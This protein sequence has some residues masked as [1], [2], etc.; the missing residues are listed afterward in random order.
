MTNIKNEVRDYAARKFIE[1]NPEARAVV[2]KDYCFVIPTG[3]IDDNGKEQ[4][5]RIGITSCQMND[6]KTRAG[7]N[8]ETDSIPALE[9]FENMLAERAANEAAREA[10][11]AAK[12]SKKKN[13]DD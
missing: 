12:K 7:F 11:R 5:A 1:N 2:G 10:E 9:A 6:T 4:Y 3:I 8:P 13:E